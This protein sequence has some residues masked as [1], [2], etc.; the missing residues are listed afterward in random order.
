MFIHWTLTDIASLATVTVALIS[1]IYTILKGRDTKTVLAG[2]ASSLKILKIKRCPLDEKKWHEMKQGK[3][4]FL[5]R[6]IGLTV[7][8]IV[9]LIGMASLLEETIMG[10]YEPFTISSGRVIAIFAILLTY[11]F[12]AIHM[13]YSFLITGRSPEDAR[14]FVFQEA[15]VLVEAEYSYLLNRCR[16]VLIVMHA[17]HIDIDAKEHCLEA[18]LS[19]RVNAVAGRMKV[20]IEPKEDNIYLLKVNF[21]ASS[22]AL[23]LLLPLFPKEEAKSRAINRFIRQLVGKPEMIQDKK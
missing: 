17:K 13:V 7:I 2:D 11:L 9:I 16:E 10:N 5:F 3:K 14:F 6:E 22:T 15:D 18:Y 8:A 19:Q 20:Q 23:F 12:L 4:L 1:V 21:C